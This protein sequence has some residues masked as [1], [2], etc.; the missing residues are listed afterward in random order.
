[1]WT[2]EAIAGV[3]DALN[4]PFVGGRYS[5]KWLLPD[6]LSV[7]RDLHGG[8]AIFLIG[9]AI[10]VSLPATRR[11]ARIDMWQ[12][13]DGRE[14]KALRLLFPSGDHFRAAAS[15]ISAELI[16]RDLEHR[17][18]AEVFPDVEPFIELMISRILLPPESALGLLG[19][20]IVLRAL[21]S[22]L[23]RAVPELRDDP[24]IAWKGHEQKS[25]DFSVGDLSIEVKTTVGA[26]A[27]HQVGSL[28]QVEPRML[29]GGGVE[30]LYLASLGLRP[31]AGTGGRSIAGEVDAVLDL[32]GPRG[33]TRTKG[34]EAFL[35]RVKA[36]GRLAGGLGYDH[37]LMRDVQPYSTQYELA[38]PV[39]M[40]DLR[41][42]NMLLPRRAM[43]EPMY[44]VPDSLAFTTDL[45]EKVTGSL[46]NPREMSESLFDRLLA[47][48][49]RA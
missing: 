33:G 45:P 27:Q 30:V 3:L 11:A 4:R 36:Y 49:V 14:F 44:L 26:L 47:D 31:F 18:A 5:V 39:R 38:R 42:T 40:Y 15:A 22:P 24:T 12:D 35:Q 17:D 1:M 10:E 28:R 41:D 21:L 32:L 34:Q 13:G 7:G 37:D 9:D 25:R 48:R 16:L 19:E 46:A 8:Y 2:Y 29:D 23:L 20:L 43:L 6:R